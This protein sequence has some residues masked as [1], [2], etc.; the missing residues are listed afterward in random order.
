MRNGSIILQFEHGQI[1]SVLSNPG[2]DRFY[3]R[4][5]RHA[6]HSAKKSAIGVESGIRLVVFGSFWLEARANVILRNALLLELHEPAFASALWEA[7]KRAALPDKLDL[8]LAL[9]PVDLQASYGDLS[10]RLRSLLEL[11]NR[12]AHFKDSDTPIMGTVPSVEEAIKI[13]TAAEDPP[14]IRNLK[15]PEVLKHAETVLKVSRWLRQVQK[16]HAKRR[17]VKIRGTKVPK[18][19]TKRSKRTRSERR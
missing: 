15:R 17:G 7:L 6:Y 19:L 16:A 11:R 14:L 9:A 18:G 2:L 8:L 1:I 4:L 13:M 5:F 12:L 3:E 10:T